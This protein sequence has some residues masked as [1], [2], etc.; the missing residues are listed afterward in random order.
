ASGL[1]SIQSLGEVFTTTGCL[2]A[3]SYLI[4]VAGGADASG[5]V[6]VSLTLSTPD[7][8]YDQPA[9]ALNFGTISGTTSWYNYVLGCHST[10][11]GE[12]VCPSLPAY[13]QT[14]WHVFSTD[15]YL[16]R[17][18][19]E[20]QSMTPGV[21]PF[22]FGFQL[23]QGDC[24]NQPFSQLIPIGPCQLINAQSELATPQNEQICTLFPQTVYSVQLFFAPLFRA[25]VRV[26][27]R[28]SGLYPAQGAN[29][30]SLP[31]QMQLGELQNGVPVS[32][33][34][35]LGCSALMSQNSC[36]ANM[37][38]YV[39]FQGDTFRY[40]TWTTFSLT[41]EGMLNVQVTPQNALLLLY[42]GD[43]TTVAD[44]CNLPL[45][46][47]LSMENDVC[48]VPP[49]VYSLQV[50]TQELSE[51]VNLTVEYLN[52]PGFYSP[53]NPEVIGEV[54]E[55][56][57]GTED[58][59]SCE[60][61]AI[62]VVQN[63]IF[64]SAGAPPPGTTCVPPECDGVSYGLCPGEYLLCDSTYNR[65]IFRKFRLNQPKAIE[66]KNISGS[67]PFVFMRGEIDVPGQNLFLMTSC[68]EYYRTNPCEPLPPGWYTVI[69]FG[70][71]IHVGAPT[72]VQI[73][74][75]D[76]DEFPVSQFNEPENAAVCNSG[77]PL[78]WELIQTGEIERSYRTY[79]QVNGIPPEYVGC[80]ADT[81]YV[82][83]RPCCPSWFFNRVSH[84]VFSL[85]RESYV[86]LNPAAGDT[87]VQYKLYAGNARINPQ[88]L[89]TDDAVI[90]PCRRCNYTEFCRLQPGE[91]TL[92]MFIHQNLIAAAP[93]TP[94]ILVDRVVRSRYD[95]AS[96]TFDAGPLPPGQWLETEADFISCATGAQGSDP[97]LFSGAFPNVCE[98]GLYPPEGPDTPYPMPPNTYLYPDW[99]PSDTVVCASNRRNLWYSFQVQAAGHVEVKVERLTPGVPP[100]PFSVWRADSMD[101]AL[102]LAQTDIDSTVEQGLVFVA[103]NLESPTSCV[104]RPTISFHQS[105]CN[106]VR[107]FLL[108]DNRSLFTH[109]VRPM[110]RFIPD[111]IYPGDLCT[112]AVGLSLPQAPS[113]AAASTQVRCHTIG[114]GYGE[115]GSNMGCLGDAGALQS[116]WFRVEVGGTSDQRFNLSFAVNTP[117]PLAAFRVLY[118]D[119]GAMTPF[120][121]GAAAGFTVTCMPP[122]NY[123]VQVVTPAGTTGEV[124][125]TAS[126]SLTPD[127]SCERELSPVVAGFTYATDCSTTEVRFLNQS[128][129]GT[130]IVYEWNFD[131]DGGCCGVSTAK[132]PRVTYPPSNE[133][134]TYRVRLRVRNVVTNIEND[135]LM[136]VVVYPPMAN[137][138]MSVSG[139]LCEGGEV[140]LSVPAGFQAYAWSTGETQNVVRVSQPGTYSALVVAAGGCSTV[141][142]RTVISHPAP[143][144]EIERT[145]ADCSAGYT[146]CYKAKVQGGAPPYAYF[147]NTLSGAEVECLSAGTHEL[148]VVDAVGCTT[149]TNWSVVTPP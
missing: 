135:T 16:D 129:S 92:V 7:P 86:L 1:P 76:I 5:S 4:Q 90:Q 95:H 142:E 84:Y 69:S 100:V 64:G 118:G 91:Y 33:Q 22:Q 68:T 26:R 116:T 21:Y 9:T 113:S 143:T 59:F 149:R 2:S 115:D 137:V 38:E 131:V 42:A 144:V 35:V 77:Q 82:H 89:L 19:F 99:F 57:Q 71:S 98:T 8:Q 11:F 124:E 18:I 147:W 111:I 125:L 128:T 130:N 61:M 78:R 138:E 81:P 139:V 106:P 96:R 114:E 51:T 132:N 39:V 134:K 123:Y 146:A 85:D 30:G 44:Y 56:S 34:D 79:N 65:F 31:P 88:I 74:I 148:K 119:C 63:I 107:Y 15:V 49:N 140:V 3:G 93:I 80:L 53:Q 121:C 14:S 41:D 29:P 58:Y 37:P 54:V 133:P 28:E 47:N 110:I 55:L 70:K 103:N 101:G 108:V 23:Y 75:L 10:D 102:P 97:P 20:L 112:G 141:V 24:R 87:N 40:N 105:D 36:G 126:S 94:T 46:Y 25:E 12:P 60:P 48:G 13:P 66:I 136:D 52:S 120:Q 83:I 45:M 122:G 73:S 145:S 127:Q 62:S 67:F 117:A 50:L 6:N 72:N 32:I 109:K 43:I 104:F 27:L 17:L